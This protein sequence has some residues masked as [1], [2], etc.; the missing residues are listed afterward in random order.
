MTTPGLRILSLR[1]SA[2]EQ[3]S[4]VAHPR[5]KSVG[6]SEEAGDVLISIV[7]DGDTLVAQVAAMK[8]GNDGRRI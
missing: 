6:L 1:C 7:V 2:E 4:T 5:D 3:C 8:A